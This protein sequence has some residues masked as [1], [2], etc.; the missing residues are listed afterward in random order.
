MIG[1][2]V[3]YTQDRFPVDSHPWADLEAPVNP[4]SMLL[5]WDKFKKVMRWA[6]WGP[7]T[8]SQAA[9]YTT[10]WQKSQWTDVSPYKSWDQKDKWMQS[11]FKRTLK[12]FSLDFHKEAFHPWA[13]LPKQ[14]ILHCLSCS[15]SI[16]KPHLTGKCQTPGC[17]YRAHGAF[18]LSHAELKP[19]TQLQ[20]FSQ[21]APSKTQRALY[22]TAQTEQ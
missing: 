8:R 7:R 18:F 13:N 4:K 6:A 9:H 19:A 1:Q 17:Q 20:Q 14:W 5:D 21:A 2:E 22:S 16:F 12:W 15:F 10:T 3:D 11:K